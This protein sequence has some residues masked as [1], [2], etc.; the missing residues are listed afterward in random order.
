MSYFHFCLLN[1]L[2]ISRF[3]SFKALKRIFLNNNFLQRRLAPH[4]NLL[5]LCLWFPSSGY[6]C[7][8]LRVVGESVG[9]LVGY[10]I[11]NQSFVTNILITLLP[12]AQ[13]SISWYSQSI[14]N[15]TC[16]WR[17]LVFLPELTTHPQQPFLSFCVLWFCHNV[18]FFLKSIHYITTDCPVPFNLSLKMTL[19]LIS[20]E[21]KPISTAQLSHLTHSLFFLRSW[22]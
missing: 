8:G 20:L 4:S 22:S 13:H 2:C 10:Q 17:F 15:I 21:L 16:Y 5:S 9:D 12:K 11:V 6:S 14:T 7:S 1:T 3:S 19:G 18:Y